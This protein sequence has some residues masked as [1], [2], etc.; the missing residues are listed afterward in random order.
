MSLVRMEN[1]RG[2]WFRL[3]SGPLPF[4]KQS[5]LAGT[6]FPLTWIIIKLQKKI[7]TSS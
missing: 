2:W 5:W 7:F 6:G 3:C 4:R 1:V